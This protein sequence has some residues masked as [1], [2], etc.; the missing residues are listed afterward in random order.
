MAGANP[1][2][3]CR[4]GELRRNLNEQRSTIRLCIPP[5]PRWAGSEVDFWVGFSVLTPLNNAGSLICDPRVVDLSSGAYRVV[6]HLLI[7]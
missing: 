2:E 6:D 5:V 1:R 7:P 3:I 4:P